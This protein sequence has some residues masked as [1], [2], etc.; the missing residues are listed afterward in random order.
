MQVLWRLLDVGES[1]NYASEQERE[2]IR[3]SSPAWCVSS[4]Y[5]LCKKVFCLLGISERT[6]EVQM[7]KP[8][9]GALAPDHGNGNRIAHNAAS[10]GQKDTVVEFLLDVGQ[11]EGIPNPRF[12]FN[13]REGARD[14][15]SDLIHLP[16]HFSK[17]ALFYK[18]LSLEYASSPPAEPPL[19]YSSFKTIF[20][21]DP[22]LSHITMSTQV[23]GV[24]KTCKL[25]KKEI[26][27][28]R[29]ENSL[30][31][32]MEEL[33]IHLRDAV[34]QRAGYKERVEEA[35]NSWI[36]DVDSDRLSVACIAFDFAASCYLPSIVREAQGDWMANQFGLEMHTTP[37]L[38]L[39]RDSD[40]RIVTDG[41]G[42]FKTNY[43]AQKQVMPA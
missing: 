1:R 22:R 32:K 33:R 38:L 36:D 11:R 35:I 16:P 3:Q 19:G 10:Q 7:N 34:G 28:Q 9:A 27:T 25:L 20:K 41:E 2:W 23:T 26:P 30:Q 14:E 5:N 43:Q 18:Y 17:Q 40:L 42:K 39:D 12:T 31:E 6:L 24:C 29:I 37:R 8:Y 4:A 13:D 21:E 15:V